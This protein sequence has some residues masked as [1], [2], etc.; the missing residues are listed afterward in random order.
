MNPRAEVVSE[1]RGVGLGVWYG[2]IPGAVVAE[3]DVDVPDVPA[4]RRAVPG[5]AHIQRPV[6]GTVG[7]RPVELVPVGLRHRYRP[8]LDPGRVVDVVP[9]EVAERGEGQRGREVAKLAPALAPGCRVVEAGG[10]ELPGLGVAEGL[11][12]VGDVPIEAPGVEQPVGR[13]GLRDGVVHEPAEPGD[14]Q[15]EGAGAADQV[16]VVPGADGVD[17]LVDLDRHPGEARVRERLDPVVV[18]VLDLPDPHPWVREVER[19]EPPSP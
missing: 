5:L 3:G 13:L 1:T 6:D 2:A 15:A 17:A 16:G 11:L 14:I 7:G 10:A 12:A 18:A 19:H 9:G 8:R 4:H